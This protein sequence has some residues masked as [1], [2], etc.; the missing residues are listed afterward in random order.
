[1]PAIVHILSYCNLLIIYSVNGLNY[2]HV[3]ISIKVVIY[4]P[5]SPPMSTYCLP[6][7]LYHWV[8]CYI[9]LAG[10]QWK[11]RLKQHISHSAHQEIYTA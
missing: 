9:A 8:D 3:L 1:M 5:P 2:L 7:A 11:T 4:P 10:C 6:I